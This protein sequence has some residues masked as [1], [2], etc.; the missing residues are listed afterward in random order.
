M[1][2]ATYAVLTLSVEQKKERAFITRILQ[3]LRSYAR[4]PQEIDP[5]RLQTQLN[6]L[7]RF[8]E[9]R[10]QHKV[11]DC[12]MPAVR[13]ATDEADLLLADLENLN[14][15]GGNMLRST[16][17]RLQLAFGKGTAQIKMLCST[18][19][20]YCRNLLERLTKEEQELLPLAQRVI[21]SEQ[22]FAIGATFLSHDAGHDERKR[23]AKR[24]VLL[25]VPI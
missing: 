2:I 11:E 25:P 20:R 4:K 8:A 5:L 14:R 23:S 15:V 17:R 24:R 19:E 10:H 21:S 6:E 18:L 13:E 16:R 22:W 9:A 1:L 3:Y 12:L 7:A